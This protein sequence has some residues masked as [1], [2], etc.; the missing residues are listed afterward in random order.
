MGLP[1]CQRVSWFP[2]KCIYNS[3]SG[4]S[5]I[6]YLRW[7]LKWRPQITISNLIVFLFET[8]LVGWL[9]VWEIRNILNFR[10]K[11]QNVL[12]YYST[13]QVFIRMPQ[14]PGLAVTPSNSYASL[15]PQETQPPF[16]LAHT[17]TYY[18][19]PSA[20]GG[21]GTAQMAA[22]HVTPLLSWGYRL[23]LGLGPGLGRFIPRLDRIF[24]GLSACLPQCRIAALLPCCHLWRVP[25]SLSRVCPQNPG[26]E[27][28]VPACERRFHLSPIFHAHCALC[29]R[30]TP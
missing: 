30:M 1:N 21:D 14:A 7:G 20:P 17:F 12:I 13:D 2:T 10:G 25:M 8:N 6:D 16:H 28:R 26:R 3:V 9:S 18:R 4:L 11:W 23:G 27:S 19:F 29:I 5:L 24:F 22:Q 15:L